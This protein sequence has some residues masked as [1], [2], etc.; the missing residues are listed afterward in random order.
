MTYDHTLMANTT[1]KDVPM[2]RTNIISDECTLIDSNAATVRRMREYSCIS[3]VQNT[4][5]RFIMGC[6]KFTTIH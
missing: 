2:I 3:P 5:Q 1:T 4:S 6:S